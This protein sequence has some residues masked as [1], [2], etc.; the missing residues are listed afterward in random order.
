MSETKRKPS[1]YLTLTE[2]KQ[3]IDGSG[4]GESGRKLEKMFDVNTTVIGKIL[5]NKN[6]ILIAYGQNI[7]PD[8]ERN[9]ERARRASY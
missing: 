8:H 9:L 1:K 2:K 3:V 7:N 6:G 5:K 4:V